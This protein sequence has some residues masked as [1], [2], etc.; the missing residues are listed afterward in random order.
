MSQEK[1]KVWGIAGSLRKDSWNKKLINAVAR[2][3]PEDVEFHV[4]DKLPQVPLF[5]EDL[6]DD[7]P[8]VVQTIRAEIEAADGVMLA[9]PEYNFGVPG[10]MKNLLDW[11]GFP[12]GMNCLSEKPVAIMGASS[13]KIGT[14]RGQFSMRHIFV[15]TRSYVLPG[16]E[17]LVSAVHE[18]MDADGNLTD[19]V[20]HDRIAYQFR[21][22]KKF[23]EFKDGTPVVLP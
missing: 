23:A 19:P 8:E 22:L 3:A 13:S 9:S 7:P 14:A 5:N 2:L 11:I 4:C 12:L 20:Y 1:F 21:M 17:V 10:V 6:L 18:V 16:P 15:A